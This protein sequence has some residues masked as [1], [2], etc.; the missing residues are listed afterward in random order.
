MCVCVCAYEYVCMCVCVGRGGVKRG[1]GGS[2]VCVCAYV[3]TVERTYASDYAYVHVQ[4]N[5]LLISIS[6]KFH[7]IEQKQS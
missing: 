7:L 6:K 4:C 3:R 2:A 1:W 5:S